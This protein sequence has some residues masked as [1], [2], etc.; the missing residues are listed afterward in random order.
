MY[1]IYIFEFLA[2]FW[3]WEFGWRWLFFYVSI[4]EFTTRTFS[5]S[6]ATNKNIY[7]FHFKWFAI[8]KLLTYVSESTDDDS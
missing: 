7:P 6:V 1:Y 5:S 2:K 3:R 4:Y 8:V